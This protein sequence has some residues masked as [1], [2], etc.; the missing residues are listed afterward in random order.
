MTKLLRLLGTA[1]LVVM[2]IRV[3]DWIL[4]PLLPLLTALFVMTLVAYVVL[5]GRRG[6]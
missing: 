1:V 3:L 4:T 5:S 2:T 6:L